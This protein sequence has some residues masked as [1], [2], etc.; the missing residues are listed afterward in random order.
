MRIRQA[1]RRGVA[2]V[3]S[4]AAVLLSATACAGAGAMGGGSSSG[5][6]ITVA[7]VAN[8][9]MQDMETLTSSFEQSHPGVHVHYVTLPENEARQKITES[10]ATGSREFDVVMISNYETPMW[11]RNGWLV[12]LQPYA[13]RTPAYDPN[14][15]VGPVRA[16]LSS[17]GDL[18]SVPFYGESSFLMYRKDLFAA[19][20]LTMPAHPT[21]TQVATLAD[22]LNDPAHHM[23]GICL[24]GVP[25]WGE[26]LAPLNTVINTFGGRW[27]DPQWN[28]Q[29]TSPAVEKAVGFYT[30]L[31]RRDG[32]PGAPTAG[33]TECGTDMTQG[34]AAMW[35]DATSA[36]G[37]LE[38]PTSSKVVGKIGYVAAPVDKTAYSGWL[39]TWSLGIPKTSTHQQAAWQFMSWATSKDYIKLVGEKLGWSRVP[40]GSRNSTYQIPQYQKAAA[41]FAGPTLQAISSTDPAHSTVE[42]VPY[43]GV[44]FLD[45][46]E[47]EDLGTRVSQQITAAI[48]GQQSVHAALAQSQQYAQTV[49]RTY[50]HS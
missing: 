7:I 35:Y 49:G 36:A 19:H 27:Y 5:T 30:D 6:T 9:Q 24:R 3:A 33:F 48:A 38:D 47:F 11:A 4:I 12:D 1:G 46:P 15:L 25:G 40:P 16:S 29:L 14:D 32:E 20:H 13:D 21:W 50:Q 45:I 43:T 22:K 18:Y 17:H 8:P 26:N 41:A 44:Q 10:V 37:S 39:Y 34:T 2:A 28:A 23:A 31:L 42:P